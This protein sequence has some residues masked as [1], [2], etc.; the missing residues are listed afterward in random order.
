MEADITNQNHENPM[1]FIYLLSI[2]MGTISI[3]N[4]K[5]TLDFVFI[6]LAITGA[7]INIYL[8]CKKIFTKKN[9]EKDI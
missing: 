6:C 2:L 9:W 3:Y 1:L 5:P 8:G 7:I 4:A